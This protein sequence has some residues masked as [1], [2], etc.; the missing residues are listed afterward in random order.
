[1]T[2]KSISQLPDGDEVTASNL[3]PNVQIPGVGPVKTTADQL[4]TFTSKITATGATT[5]ISLQDRFGE[6]KTFRDFGAVGDGVTDD[7]A[8]VQAAFNEAGYVSGVPG[9][10]YALYD[11]VYILS[12]TYFNGNGSEFIRKYTDTSWMINNASAYTTHND[13]NI[14]LDNLSVKDDG[15]TASRGSFVNLSGVDGFSINNFTVYSRSP[16]YLGRAAEALLLSANNGTITNVNIDGYDPAVPSLYMDGIHLGY[17]ENVTIDGG[18]VKCYDDAISLFGFGGTYPTTVE[19]APSKNIA[20]SNMVLQSGFANAIR[21]GAWGS[22]FITSN[23]NPQKQ[24]WQNIAFSNIV[25]KESANGITLYDDRKNYASNVSVSNMYVGMVCTIQALNDG[26]GGN[27]T[28]FTEFG[29]PDNTI[30]TTFTVTSIPSSIG[31]GKISNNEIF[32][33]AIQVSAS[34][35]IADFMCVITSV[36]NTD[37]TLIG[38]SSNTVGTYFRATSAASGTGTVILFTPLQNT[39]ISFNNIVMEKEIGVEP[40]ATGRRIYL[41]GHYDFLGSSDLKQ[42]NFG[43]VV[44]GEII[45]ETTV[46]AAL[47]YLGHLILASGATNVNFNN[48]YFKQDSGAVSPEY[49]V[50]I[51]RITNLYFNDTKFVFNNSATAIYNSLCNNIYVNNPNISGPTNVVFGLNGSA[52]LTTNFYMNGGYILD[53]AIA[54]NRISANVSYYNDFIVDGTYSDSSFADTNFTDSSGAYHNNFIRPLYGF[55]SNVPNSGGRY[56]VYSAGGAPNYFA[57]NTSIGGSQ[58]SGRTLEVTKNITGSTTAYGISSSGLI[59]SDVTNS[60]YLFGAIGATQDLSFTLSNL[61]YFFA[62]KFGFGA[63]STVTNQYGLYID[64]SLT[65]AINNYGI[66]SNISLASNSWNIFIDGTANNAFAGKSRFGSTSVPANT[67][68][69][70]GSFGRGAIVSKTSDFSVGSTENWIEVNNSGTTTVTLP[71]ASSYSGREIMIKT[72]ANQS[73]ISNASNVQSITGGSLQT[74][75]LNAAAGSWATLVSDGFNW[76]I[77]QGVGTA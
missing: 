62:S 67:V 18:V 27:N 77:V 46:Q 16:E 4:R 36:G 26:V 34:N 32:S 37:F 53:S 45:A 7:T 44:F 68:D 58:T 42:Q 6:M 15:T 30:G 39:N 76:I 11:K 41:R 9:D 59:L 35:I 73:V 28:D 74:G 71:S 54:V 40:A 51:T 2:S 20:I 14:H 70:T 56:S 57:G 72:V 21:L 48:C 33:E 55:Y 50:F 13:V 1:M 17:C 8:A 52:L 19:D 24:A 25:I 47:L 75:I 22:A 66:Y 3:I 38:A 12:N 63:S 31:T 43:T 49:D 60:A 29:S 23:I 10:V 5:E 61:S 69:V 65:G 64:S